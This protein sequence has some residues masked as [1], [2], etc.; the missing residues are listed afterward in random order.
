MTL[1]DACLN[2]PD[3]VEN[4]LKCGLD[5]NVKVTSAYTLQSSRCGSIVLY[6]GVTPL[7]VACEYRPSIVP[8]LLKYGADVNISSERS[9]TPFHIACIYQPSIVPVLL[10]NGADVN[11]RTGTGRTSLHLVCI[12]HPYLIPELIQHGA[13]VNAKDVFGDLPIHLANE[14]FRLLYTL[15]KTIGDRHVRSSEFCFYNRLYAGMIWNRIP[16]VP[17]SFVLLEFM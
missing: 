3:R 17:S 9:F 8:I 12:T 11:A 14:G 6:V 5:V 1:F 7:H 10:R 2:H 16:G 4:W 15:T 13:D